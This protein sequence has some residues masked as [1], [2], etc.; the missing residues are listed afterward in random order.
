MADAVIRGN[1]LFFDG[2]TP[3]IKMTWHYQRISKN[4][5]IAFIYGY[6]DDK[7]QIIV[8]NRH[9]EEAYKRLQYMAR[10]QIDL[11]AEF[12]KVQMY[13]NLSSGIYDI[14]KQELVP[15]RGQFKFDY[16]VDIRYRPHSK[17]DDAPNFRNYVETSVGMDQYECLMRTLGYALSSLTKARK[18]CVM[19]GRPKS[20]KSSILDL[21][22]SV[23]KGDLVSHE[24]FDRMGTERAKAKYIG[25]RVNISRETNA[26]P[27]KN[28]DSFKSLISNERTTGE[29]KYEIK[30]S[31]IP[32]LFFIFAGNVDIEFAKECL[33]DAIIDRLY[34]IIYDKEIPDEKID[35]D[36]DKKLWNE[37]DVIF[38]IA[39]DSLKGLVED[40]YDF[41]EGPTAV[42][43]LR[44]KRYLI[45]TVESFLN[46]RCMISESGKVSST[47]LYEA[48]I[49][50][51]RANALTPESDKSFYGKIMS[52][53]PSIIRGRVPDINGNPVRGFHGL[54]LVG[55]EHQVI[56]EESDE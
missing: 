32:T 44:H 15:L 34:Y 51:C 55:S 50:F 23:L 11:T 48:Y 41:K 13:V 1:I 2:M 38:S 10:L 29:E 9:I 42:E 33:D 35:L 20:G 12:W 26:K 30:K 6:L 22:E 37:R 27:N 53:N 5:A 24:A 16:V 39:L 8:P 25:R 3:V 14:L 45:H 18:C 17:L 36:L 19:L 54:A 46:E 21:L 47:A 49:A 7:S 31:F 28:A 43:H 4:E 56:D 40:H 52:F